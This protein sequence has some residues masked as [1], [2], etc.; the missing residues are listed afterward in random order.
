MG[1][2]NCRKDAQLDR[3]EGVNIILK[4]LNACIC[5]NMREYGSCMHVRSSA[6]P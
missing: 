6:L 5:V 4:F 2:E 1:H 3:A